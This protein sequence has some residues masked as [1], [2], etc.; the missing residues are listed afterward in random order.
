M[1]SQS[2]I[3]NRVGV[4]VANVSKIII[5]GNH[6]VS[7]FPDVASASVVTADGAVKSVRDAVNDE[8]WLTGDFITVRKKTLN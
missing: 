4:P 2:Q 8:A 3:A 7:Q 1:F 6:S 5:W